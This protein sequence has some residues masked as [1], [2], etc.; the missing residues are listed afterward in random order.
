MAYVS[1]LPKELCEDFARLNLSIV[2]NTMELE[3]ELALER[4]IR[5]G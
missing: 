3:V 5:K 1:Q 4:E 2:A